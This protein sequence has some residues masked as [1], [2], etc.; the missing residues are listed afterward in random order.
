L[1][2]LA[3]VGNSNI[4]D[5]SAQI[6]N[7]ITSQS[8]E[9]A[10]QILNHFLNRLPII[11]LKE[12]SRARVYIGRDLLIPSYAEH[13]V[14][15]AISLKGVHHATIYQKLEWPAGCRS[16]CLHRP[17]WP[18]LVRRDL[19]RPGAVGPRTATDCPAGE[20]QRYLAN[21]EL[22]TITG[23]ENNRLTVR[24]DGETHRTVSF[25]A[26]QFQQFDHGHAMTSHSSQGLTANRV[27]AHFDTDSSYSLINTRLAYVAISRASH[28]AHIYTINTETLGRRLATDVSKTAAVD[29]R[30]RSSQ[31][32]VEV[33]VVAF[34]ARDL[35]TETTRLQE[36]GSVH[37]Y[38]RSEHRLAAVSLA[39]AA[40]PNRAV[41]VAPDANER[42]ELTHLIRGEL[43]D[44][45][46]LATETRTVAVLVRQDLGNPRLAANYLPRD[47]IHYKTGSPGEHGIANDSVVT[48]LAVNPQANTLTIVTRDGNEVSYNPALLKKQT[49]QSITYRQEVREIAVGERIRFTHSDHE[50][51]I[52]VDDFATVKQIGT[53]DGFAVRL[54][55]GSTLELDSNLARHIDYGYVVES[56]K[57]AAGK[58]VLITGDS[59]ELAQQQETFARISPRIGELD[60]YIPDSRKL[61]K[62]VPSLET[63]AH[64]AVL[65]QPTDGSLTVSLPQI[66]PEGYG[67]G[68]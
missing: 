62:S 56:A 8:S 26:A 54:D 66:E 44:Q 53:N 52:R 49:A 16:P 46:T 28:D 6:R 39:Y 23:I 68:L 42:L 3:E 13:R 7:G 65:S 1:A 27:L 24:M 55:S 19:C 35:K 22:G 18:R 25:D 4:L 61:M 36:Q 51:H 50:A 5:P 20:G 47:E 10:E 41:V 17:A 9:E 15:P 64:S 34:R 33:A 21:R 11:T 29:F 43:Q 59:I 31:P 38:A 40:D 2:G 14:E 57:A 60:L 32:E 12:G 30:P 37:E 45:G 63:E 58:R 67:I 48:V